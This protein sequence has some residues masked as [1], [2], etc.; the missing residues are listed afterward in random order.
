MLDVFHSY[1]QDR[2]HYGFIY[3]ENTKARTIA[4]EFGHGTNSLHHTFSH[5]SET[6]YTT[7]KTDNLMDY[8]EGKTLTHTQWQWSHE[9]HRNVLGFLDDEG[10]GESKTDS[11]IVKVIETENTNYGFDV[12]EGSSE[13]YI[14]VANGDVTTFRVTSNCDSKKLYFT[15]NG[16]ADKCFSLKIDTLA[17][18]NAFDITIGSRNYSSDATNCKFQ[19]RLDSINGIIKKEIQIISYSI[20][21]T[22]IKLLK[23][24]CKNLCIS[25]SSLQKLLDQGV[26]SLSSFICDSVNIKFDIN[27]NGALDWFRAGD[28][29]EFEI[30]KNSIGENTENTMV[31]ID[32]PIHMS[33]RLKQ[34]IK[35]GSSYFVAEFND[36]KLVAGRILHISTDSIDERVTIKEVINDTIYVNGEIEND[37]SINDLV[38]REISGLSSNPQLIKTGSSKLPKSV[39]YSTIV[40]ERLHKQPFGLTDLSGETQN[41][42]NIMLYKTSENKKKLRNRP[43]KVYDGTRTEKQ[44]DRIKRNAK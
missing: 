16:D 7:S 25:S 35:K 29:P 14:S 41:M 11:I 12:I 20:V 22:D 40:H 30:I 15:I 42:D 34:P 19:I 17:S 44:W 38:W 18:N 3:N 13:N 28:N 10:E 32:V 23:L 43:L 31:I 24:N 5:E 1:K 4:H 26:I 2:R 8:N 27:N 37:F 33:V 39:V 9:K 6:F 36:T 21:T